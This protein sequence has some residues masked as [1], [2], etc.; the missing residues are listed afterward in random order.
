MKKAY[1]ITYDS[2]YKNDD[3]LLKEE[4]KK[5][6]KWWHYLDYTWIIISEESAREIWDRIK[7]KI[8][9]HNGL[10]IIEVGTQAE[11]WLD[12]TAWDWIDENIKG[13]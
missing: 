2:E 13:E 12:R 1:L 3:Y 5:N 7:N 4:L 6:K 8:N 10:L 11:G 9:Q